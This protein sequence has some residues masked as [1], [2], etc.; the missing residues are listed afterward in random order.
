MFKFIIPIFISWLVSSEA[1]AHSGGLNSEGCHNN[2]KTGVYHCHRGSNS[3]SFSTGTI[4]SVMSEDMFNLILARKLGGKTE[5]TYEYIFGQN[6]AGSIRVDIVT[7]EY[8]IEGGKDTRSSL[9][10]IQQSVFAS[11]VTNKKPAVAIF[12]TDGVWGKYEHRIWAASN[13]LGVKFIWF[14]RGE[15]RKVN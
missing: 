9:D 13:K 7:D 5:V 2:S 6:N 11:T 1:T 10:S 4:Q 8:V 12:D 14:S 3:S 15:I